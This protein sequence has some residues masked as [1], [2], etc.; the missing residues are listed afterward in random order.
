M[1]N[2]MT[3]RINL[4]TNVNEITSTLNKKRNT[5]DASGDKKDNPDES[6][7]ILR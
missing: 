2:E 5:H 1:T 4:V 3:K 7:G 6:K